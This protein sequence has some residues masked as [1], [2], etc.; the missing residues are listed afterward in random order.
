MN[1]SVSRWLFPLLVI[2]LAA[3]LGACKKM[4]SFRPPASGPYYVIQ[5][6][7]DSLHWYGPVG[8][9]IRY[10]LARPIETLPQ[11]EP[12][13]DLSFTPLVSE[14][15]FN[16]VKKQKNVVIAAPIDQDTPTAR[17][18]K[19]RMDSTVLARV[20]SGQSLLITRPDLWYRDQMV[21]YLVGPRVDSLSAFIH[22]EGENLRYLFN[23]LARERL[24]K[25][26]FAPGRE[27][28]IEKYLLEHHGF[29]VNVQLDYVLVQDTMLYPGTGFVRLR[30]ILPDTWRDF[31]VFYIEK[32]DPMVINTDWILAM[33]D[34][35]TYH[36][37]RGTRPESYVE[38]DRRRPLT[39]EAIN[40]LDRFGY[41]TRGL[42]HMTHDAM[43]GPFLNYTFYEET[44]GRIYM[45]DGMV[46]APGY[47]K[48]EFLRQLEVI[49]Y[50]FRTRGEE[51]VK[52]KEE[53]P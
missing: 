32:G 39:S 24:A 9:A 36:F 45:F 53:T 20:Q 48:R 1:T 46:F 50:T 14:Q 19:A 25:E 29:A 44:Q 42:W 5:V 31:F 2:G 15:L 17:F 28:E 21:I 4:A 43:G 52:Q 3:W 26:M 18:L 13:F 47:P 8:D 35:L 51:K 40:F 11:P 30:R 16:Q 6:V 27:R 22:R 38:V 33:R 7:T 23:K 34:T 49:A 10:E 41:E 12:M 37:V